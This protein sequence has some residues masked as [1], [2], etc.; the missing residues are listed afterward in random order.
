LGCLIEDHHQIGR[1]FDIAP[2]YGVADLNDK[3]EWV[4]SDLSRLD[5]D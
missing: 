2:Q 3:D 4:V 1:G 5:C